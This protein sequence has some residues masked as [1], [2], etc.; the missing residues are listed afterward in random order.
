MILNNDNIELYLFRY[1]E[2]LLEE[3]EMAEVEQALASHREWRELADLYDTELTLPSGAVMAY[4]DVESLRDGGPKAGKAVVTEERRPI[5]LREPDESKGRRIRPM[6]ISLVAAACLLLF[7]VT[8][9]R[10]V[11]SASSVEGGAVLAGTEV[12]IELET[13]TSD[14]R[15]ADAE[16]Q[17]ATPKDVRTKSRKETVQTVINDDVQMFAA[18]ENDAVETFE[19]AE[20]SAPVAVDTN[21]YPVGNATTREL[22]D[23]MD[24]EVLYANIIDWQRGTSEPYDSP[25]RRRQLRSIA[26]KATSIIATAASNY[27]ER[28]DEVEDAIE[29]R[30][31]SNTL[32]NNIIA[33]IE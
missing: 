28:R 25:S 22:N 21:R 8:V 1:K 17:P 32:L 2:G 10:F 20:E 27:D 29:E 26:R 19:E 13:K 11:N 12:P 14:S 6:W 15:M 9:V 7:V 24:Q 4:P 30:I 5:V 33:T 23:P 18:V 16:E 3:A 31:Q